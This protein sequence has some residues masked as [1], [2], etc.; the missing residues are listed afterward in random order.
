MNS[1]M[2]QPLLV[3]QDLPAFK[4][5]LPKIASVASGMSGCTLRVDSSHDG[6]LGELYSRPAPLA[7]EQHLFKGD[8]MDDPRI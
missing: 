5:S 8:E 7:L 4:F 6:G 2:A 3:A 1:V